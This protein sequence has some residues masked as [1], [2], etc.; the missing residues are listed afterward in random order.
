M[1]PED[2]AVIELKPWG[3]VAGRMLLGDKP[4]VGAKYWVYQ[5]RTDNVFV[6]AHYDV[7]TDANGR[8]V[9][10]RI[11]AGLHGICQRYTDNTNGQGSHALSGL[12]ARF[13]IPVGK[14]ATLELGSPGRTLVGKLALPEGFPHKIDWSKVSLQVSL[15]PPRFSGRFGGN[16]ESGQSWSKFLQTDEGKLYGR[17][18]VTIAADGSFRIEG[19]PAA[20]YQLT[21]SADRQAVLD[22]PKSD[23]DVLRGIEKF[24]VPAVAPSDDTEVIDLGTIKLTSLVALNDA[25][26]PAPATDATATPAWGPATNGLRARVVPVLSS[27]SEDA[28]DPAQRVAK[29]E[30]PD[31]VAFAV[32]LENVSDQPIKLLDTRYG[33]SFGA[34]SGKANSNW[35]GQFLFSIDL[36]DS[37]GK[38]IERPEVEVVTLNMIL[39]SVSVATVEPGKTHRFLLRPSQWLS[40][41]RRNFEPG[42]YRVAV[43]Y[44]GMP[45]RVVTRIKEYKPESPVFAAVAGD[46]VTPPVA[47]EV[48][49]VG[50]QPATEKEKPDEPRTDPTKPGKLEAY[51][52]ALVWGEPTNGI[53]A[54]LSF[55]PAKARHA[56]GE[57]LE[58]NMHV[59]NVSDQPITVASQLWM[60]DLAAQV[61]N[62]KGEP[63]QVGGTFYS[64][65]TPVVRVTLKPRQIA[66]FGAGNIGLAIT[67]E[68]AG[69]FEHITNRTLVAPAGKYTMQLAERFGNSFFLKDGKGNVLAPLPGD[70][71]GEVKTGVTPFEITNESIECN[72]IDAVTGKPVTGTTVNFRFIKPKSGDVAEEIVED[73]FWGPQAPSSLYFFIPDKVLARADRD[74]IEVAWGIG[75]HADYE[76]LS[77]DQRIPLKPFFHEGPKAARETLG[78]IKLTPKKQAAA[79]SPPAP[80]GQF[81]RQV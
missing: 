64:G 62:D 28:I 7:E 24:S 44:H 29:F 1:T 37:D 57:K 60:S 68:R 78:T 66:V 9:V 25:A 2:T 13:E 77:S 56:H 38:L 47:F 63:V 73:V 72:I 79:T 39:G 19:L 11:P 12:L 34:S 14:T 51:P 65:S 81:E 20:E 40:L 71:V 69:N 48:G 58:L 42:S 18:K 76:P 3:R 49:G 74:E 26:A 30:R 50:F 32:E 80:S 43:R 46:I 54:A 17:D 10:E 4:V 59:E 41:Y 36:Y 61:K 55:A 53:R 45:P 27:M 8:F 67:G 6:R 75:G 52:T 33:N 35:Y 31:D 23:G 21:V 70:F 16:D 15:Q 22:N 5:A